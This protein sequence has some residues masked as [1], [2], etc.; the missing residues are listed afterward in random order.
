M[1][2]TL[3]PTKLHVGCGR[4]YIP[5]FLHIDIQPAPHIDMVAEADNLEEIADDTVELLYACHI[6]EHFDRWHYKRALAE[7]FRVLK[8]GGVLRL[9]VPDFAACV[10]V[11]SKVGIVGG[12]SSILGL[13]CGGQRDS[14]DFHKMLFDRG[15]L[16]KALS[17]VGFKEIRD[18]DWRATEHTQV[19]D[20]S[21][22]YLPHLDKQNGTQMSL[23]IEAV[24]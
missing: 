16:S 20:Y 4:V 12:P 10:T 3:L 2:K 7:W 18:W 14:F 23:N 6:L 19:D 22:A 24:K 15:S 17:D 1:K 8:L 9:S 11:Y 13:I 5:G 21:Q